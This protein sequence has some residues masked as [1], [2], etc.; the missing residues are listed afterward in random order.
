MRTHTTTK[1]KSKTI[2]EKKPKKSRALARKPVSP[3]R[4]TRST[5]VVR[6]TQ[7]KTPTR[8]PRVIPK[9]STR[10]QDTHPPKQ[11]PVIASQEVQ[12]EQPMLYMYIRIGALMVFCA[13][14]L[15]LL[16]LH[17][18]PRMTP[19]VVSQATPPVDE[20]VRIPELPH[21][22]T[23]ALFPASTPVK[24]RIPALAIDT[25]FE[26]PLGLREDQTIQVPKAYD[27]VGWYKYGVTPGEIGTAAVLGHIDSYKGPAVFYSLGQL[28]SGDYVFITR[29][30][31]TEVVF[32]I[33]YLERYTQ[34][35]FPTEKVYGH[36]PYP[37]LR[38]ITCS[39]IYKKD[40]QRYTH[41]LVVYARLYDQA[42][43]LKE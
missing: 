11:E 24:L 5:R 19:I 7:T 6:R 14:I 23:Y 40:T 41:N 18:Y 30:D 33:E 31:G 42:K 37:S 15:T 2:V 12:P 20:E 10:T 21:E 27:T 43:I 3:S 4:T 13:S 32:E 35:T 38:L 39:G 17:L 28:K 34:D 26:A 29:A 8:P 1:T 25:Q 9:K 36:T 16:I 22:E